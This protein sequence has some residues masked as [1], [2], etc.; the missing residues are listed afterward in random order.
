M[1]NA[2]LTRWTVLGLLIVVNILLAR[3]V[4]QRH[5]VTRAASELATER[6]R[7]K[8]L[9]ETGRYHNP[10]ELE[11]AFEEIRQESS[12]SILWIQLRDQDGS[13]QAHTGVDTPSIL[14]VKLLGY[15]SGT[16]AVDAFPI[17]W[18][19]VG[20]GT[21]HAGTIEIAARLDRVHID[22]RPRPRRQRRSAV[23]FASLIF[24]SPILSNPI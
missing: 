8:R 3:S 22:V 4:A 14:P 21:R 5:F 17:E 16:L 20:A 10:Q 9:V 19:A 18:P 15:I 11:S 7:L 2:R 13:V 24:V 12:L 23:R 1:R 6:T